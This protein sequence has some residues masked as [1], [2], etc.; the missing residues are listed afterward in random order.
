M[1]TAPIQ[2]KRTKRITRITNEG[3]TFMVKFGA[4]DEP[5]AIMERT[6]RSNG[7]LR[8][9]TYWHRT[10]G[11]P[12][13]GRNGRQQSIVRTVLENAGVSLPVDTRQFAGH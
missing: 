3:R 2:M 4:A 12:G 5:L 9:H 1:N 13:A 11:L 10:H 6:R 7:K 8:D